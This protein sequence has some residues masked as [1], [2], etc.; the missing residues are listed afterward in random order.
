[1]GEGEEADLGHITHTAKQHHMMDTC[2]YH[3]QR[4]LFSPLT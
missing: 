4:Y 1:M 3:P 2:T